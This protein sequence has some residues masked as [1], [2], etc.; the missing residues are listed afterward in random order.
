M[1]W[2]FGQNLTPWHRELKRQG[3]CWD[4]EAT[5]DFLMILLGF[6]DV[7]G[8][9]VL[10]WR[11]PNEHGLWWLDRLW[12]D[13]MVNDHDGTTSAVPTF[14]D[15]PLNWFPDIKLSE[16]ALDDDVLEVE[17]DDVGS[18]PP[19]GQWGATVHSIAGNSPVCS[20]ILLLVR[21]GARIHV[22]LPAWSISGRNACSRG[23][24][25]AVC[26]LAMGPHAALFLTSRDDGV[27]MLCRMR[28]TRT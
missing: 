6:V 23:L 19:W 28:R 8:G 20:S 1:R 27:L 2:R 15:S 4:P 22:M 10:P 17:D 13:P 9:V 18:N 14:A 16:F 7:W 21:V 11:L 12:C 25:T 5:I 24:F 3:G 26:N